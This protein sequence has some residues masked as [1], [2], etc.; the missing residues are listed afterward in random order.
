MHKKAAFLIVGLVLLAAAP[1]LA[2]TQQQG[3]APGLQKDV[4]PPAS[5]AGPGPAQK[6]DVP[7]PEV[8]SSSAAPGARIPSAN[9]APNP[10]A[11]GK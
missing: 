7:A 11:N 1:E 6:E 9:R 8:R 5:A 10:V 3:T 2:Q 4:P